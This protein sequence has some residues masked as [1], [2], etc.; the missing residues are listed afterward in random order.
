MTEL[1][2]MKEQFLYIFRPVH[3]SPYIG[4]SVHFSVPQGLLSD[5]P[6]SEHGNPLRP[7]RTC[8]DVG[9]KL[10]QLGDRRISIFGESAN[11]AP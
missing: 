10:G 1:L 6:D 8:D 2:Q 3:F 5:Q 9:G 4:S 11:K 7:V